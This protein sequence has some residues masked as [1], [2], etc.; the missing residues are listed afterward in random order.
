MWN[1]I[2]CPPY[3]NFQ[4]WILCILSLALFYQIFSLMY[5]LFCILSYNFNTPT[6]F[7]FDRN[8]N[9]FIQELYN[10]DFITGLIMNKF[11]WNKIDD[12]S[13]RSAVSNKRNL[14]DI[15]VISLKVALNTINQ[16]RIKGTYTVKK[17]YRCQGGSVFFFKVHFW[18]L[19]HI[20]IG[21]HF[22]RDNVCTI[23]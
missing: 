15:T 3:T 5:N 11:A 4:S 8:F 1:L 7:G 13:N 14:H 6:N 23:I 19:N 9:C 18:N 17:C 21:L 16:T 20:I 22:N 2:L 12:S 10:M